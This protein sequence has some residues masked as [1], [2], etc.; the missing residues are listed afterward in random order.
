MHWHPLCIPQS[1]NPRRRNIL[2]VRLKHCLDSRFWDNP[3][4]LLSPRDLSEDTVNI[5]ELSPH[6]QTHLFSHSS[7]CIVQ[8]RGTG[9]QLRAVES[10]RHGCALSF[11]LLEIN[12]LRWILGREAPRHNMSWDYCDNSK[13]MCDM[14]A[15]RELTGCILSFLLLSSCLFPLPPLPWSSSS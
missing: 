8:N 7:I 6:K 14:C 15:C 1:L 12:T 2:E 3:L 10:L 4:A 13:K 11:V 5:Y 9:L